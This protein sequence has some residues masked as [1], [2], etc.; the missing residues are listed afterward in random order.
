VNINTK[1]P[2][3]VVAFTAIVSAVFTAAIMALEVSTAER[4][5]LNMELREK[6]A[7]VEAFKLHV[8][9]DG[10][11]G[12]PGDGEVLDLYKKHI[13]RGQGEVIDPETATSY[14]IIKCFRD[15]KKDALKGYA[16]RVTGVG[17]WA[18]I[19]GYMAVT[20]D[21]NEI[22]GVCILDESETPGLGGRIKEDKICARFDGLLISKPETEGAPYIYLMREGEKPAREGTPRYH[23]QFEAITGATQTS[24]KTVGFLNRN[25]AQFRRAMA[26]GV[27][28][29]ALPEKEVK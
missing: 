2:V 13:T 16:V 29:I 7:L 20:P 26:V 25:I 21:L 4:V 1:N 3:Y 27:K 23:R 22:I 24:T 11:S 10:K 15:K 17:F 8:T 5:R 14:E 9:T 6:R 18:P 19:T 12:K 28:Q